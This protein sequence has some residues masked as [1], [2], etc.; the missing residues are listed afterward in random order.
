MKFLVSVTGHLGLKFSDYMLVLCQK[1]HIYTYDLQFF[2]GD[3]LPCPRIAPSQSGH[4]RTVA[5]GNL[6]ERAK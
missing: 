5:G 1:L 2:S 3:W 6:A 4:A